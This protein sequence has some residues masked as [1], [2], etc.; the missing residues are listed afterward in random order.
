[1]WNQILH[2]VLLKL[3]FPQTPQFPYRQNVL[4]IWNKVVGD[5]AGCLG[6]VE[7]HIFRVKL[8]NWIC[9]CNW[10]LDITESVCLYGVLALCLLVCFRFS[11]Y[12]SS[13]CILLPSGLIIPRNYVDLLRRLL[14]VGLQNARGEHI[15]LEWI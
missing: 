11:P 1:M 2:S 4:V 14:L 7:K 5:F 10:S 13:W 3:L 9:F 8:L 15:I 12:K 6:P